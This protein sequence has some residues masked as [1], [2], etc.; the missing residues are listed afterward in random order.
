MQRERIVTPCKEKQAVGR[1]GELLVE[2]VLA[3]LLRSVL[4]LELLLQIRLQSL[5]L[6]PSLLSGNVACRFSRWLCSRL[7][8]VELFSF[9]LLLLLALLV[10]CLW[11]WSFSWHWLLLLYMRRRRRRRQ[12]LKEQLRLLQELLHLF[13]LFFVFRLLLTKA[14]AETSSGS[15]RLLP[16]TRGES[17]ISALAAGC[18][19]LL[20]FWYLTLSPCSLKLV[21]GISSNLSLH[22]IP[23]SQL[24]PII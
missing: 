4:L 8:H 16:E 22:W 11:R 19:F 6:M 14:V 13:Q 1:Q 3:D 18:I 17:T 15:R 5:S 20:R 24:L 21:A 7:Q 2:C 10:I 12:S 23:I 9:V